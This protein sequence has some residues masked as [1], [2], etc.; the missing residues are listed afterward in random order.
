LVNRSLARVRT[1]L[2]DRCGFQESAFR[3]HSPGAFSPAAHRVMLHKCSVRGE[4]PREDHVEPHLGWF[5]RYP[6]RFHHEVL[7]QM[8]DGVERR[9]GCKPKTILDPFVGTGSTLSFA[10]QRRISSVGVELTPLAVLI[11]KVRLNPLEDVDIAVELAERI[12]SLETQRQ[13]H[14]FPDELV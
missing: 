10:K 7:S 5:H 11:S 13:T 12:A 8:F 1:V 9:L 6:A 14:S 4:Q 2:G 3:E